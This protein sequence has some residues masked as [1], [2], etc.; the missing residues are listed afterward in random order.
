[1][2]RP[3]TPYTSAVRLKTVAMPLLLWAASL[4]FYGAVAQSR[5]ATESQIKAL[6]LYQFSQFVEW[7]DGNGQTI[8]PFSICVLGEDPFGV[9]LDEVVKNKTTASAAVVVRRVLGVKDAAGC[10][11]AFVSPSEDGRLTEILKALDG[12]NVLTVG[13]GNPF[14]RRGGMIGFR[15]DENRVRITINLA[16]A[17]RESLKVSSHLLKLARLEGATD[18]GM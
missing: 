16:A 3:T 1:M 10:R 17:E 8:S 11:I 18:R 14:T 13:E 7:P 12:R 15:V 4:G 5:P 9:L 6:F 2:V